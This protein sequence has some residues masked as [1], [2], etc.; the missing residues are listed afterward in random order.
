MLLLVLT[1]PGEGRVDVLNPSPP[2]LGLTVVT[3]TRTLHGGSFEFQWGEGL[4]G[5]HQ[6][7][8]NM[9]KLP[10]HSLVSTGPSTG[11]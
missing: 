2:L 4:T 7:R 10:S 11:T 3:R 5:K 6:G 1:R 8:E 9:A